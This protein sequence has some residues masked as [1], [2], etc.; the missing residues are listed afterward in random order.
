M[1]ESRE[2]REDPARLIAGAVPPAVALGRGVQVWRSADAVELYFP[3]LRS[4]A[5]AVPLALFGVVTMAIPGV[6]IVAL[7]PSLIAN[8]GSLLG[9]VL[10]A[11][12]VLPFIAFG[13]SLVLISIYM[14][15]NALHVRVDAAGIAT[16]RLVFGAV[17]RRRHIAR[18][19]IAT[20]E[21]Q[22][23]TRYQSLFRAA[24]S[25]HLYART[26]DGKRTIVAETL[27]GEDVMNA[28]KALIEN[29]TDE[30]SD[31]RAP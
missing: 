7:L 4:L 20:I 27:S 11:S 17:V 28:V 31:G 25:Y 30:T 9:A 6:A 13:A 15:A 1:G 22:I 2:V 26:A 3:P 21:A 16:T 12:F 8:A 14:L 24:P 29:P 18:A 10:I 5:V 19:G 23:P